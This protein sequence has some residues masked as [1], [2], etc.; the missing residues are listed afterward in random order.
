MPGKVLLVVV[1]FLFLVAPVTAQSTHTETMLDLLQAMMRAGGFDED[2]A[3]TFDQ[4]GSSGDPLYVAPLIDLGYFVRGGNN[5]LFEALGA[6]TGE[7]FGSDW[8]AWFTWA[9]AN[10]VALPND[11]DVWKGGLFSRLI[12]PQFERFWQDVQSTARVNLLEP[13]WGGVRVDG[14]PSLVN[15]T[16]ISPEAA[17][18]EGETLTQFCRQDDCRYPAPDELVFGVS[19]DGDNRAYPLRLLLRE[20]VVPAEHRQIGTRLAQPVDI[21]GRPCL[22]RRRFALP[23]E[24]DG[25]RDKCNPLVETRPRLARAIRRESGPA[26]LEMDARGLDERPRGLRPDIERIAQPVRLEKG[27][28][29]GRLLARHLEGHRNHLSRAL[30]RDDRQPEG[31]QHAQHGAVR[32]AVSALG[33]HHRTCLSVSRG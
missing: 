22:A 24:S 25:P 23:C 4:I 32:S 9:S 5:P 27:L 14:I 31:K 13:V 1:L 28:E 3:A 8:S 2:V 12:D 16:Q 19:I 29:H 7:S 15:A 11:Y 18:I 20:G 30:P 26:R 33:A 6:L 17:Q 21:A 10:D